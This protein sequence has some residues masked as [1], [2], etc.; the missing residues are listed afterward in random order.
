MLRRSFF[1][2]GD[3]RSTPKLA[4]EFSAS[5][6]RQSSKYDHVLIDIGPFAGIG[7]RVVKGLTGHDRDMETITFIQRQIFGVVLRKYSAAKSIGLFFDGSDPL[8]KTHRTRKFPGKKF[9][10]RFYRSC[11][12]NMP[13]LCEEKLRTA[14]ADTARGKVLPEFTISGPATAGTVESKMSAYLYDLAARFADPAGAAYMDPASSIAATAAAGSAAATK[15]SF[16]SVQ[17]TDSVL[18]VGMDEAFLS[19]LGALPFSNVTSVLMDGRDLKSLTLTEGL[20]WMTLHN[21]GKPS[22]PGAAPTLQQLKARI[23]ALILYLLGNGCNSTDLPSAGLNFND[24][25]AAY[26][27]SQN[28]G[29]DG[30]NYLCEPNLPSA[31]IGIDLLKL[32]R[33]L[34]K[35]GRKANVVAR[36]DAQA[37]DYLEML[38]QT[39]AMFADGGIKNNAFVPSS[40]LVEL[41]PQLKTDVLI[42]H[43]KFLATSPSTTL[44]SVAN[45]PNGKA[46]V[47]SRSADGF[48][49]TAA[50]QLLV[51]GQLL[52][53]PS[54]SPT[55][56]S[57]EAIKAI[58]P[59]FTGGWEIP[60]KV[61]NEVTATPNVRAAAE[62]ARDVLSNLDPNSEVGSHPALRHTPSYYFYQAK[63]VGPPAGYEYVPVALGVRSEAQNTRA[64]VVAKAVVA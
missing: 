1:H 6:S 20:E 32:D 43:I 64:T 15:S 37:A 24:L 47:P 10:N 27:E 22:A 16:P 54:P 63:T 38:L 18:I 46:V 19:A 35:A 58:S 48:A 59:T 40:P 57:I 60:E 23:D 5:I 29:K 26:I 33:L 50:E 25:M 56:A 42:G 53:T 3:F 8:W 41:P 39:V 62:A 7:T 34:A 14:M 31:S 17:T 12:C 9:E 55:E 21:L 45:G 36:E 2:L 4:D 11:A 52:T 51:S 61:L 49:L 44:N 30:G 13:F 28:M